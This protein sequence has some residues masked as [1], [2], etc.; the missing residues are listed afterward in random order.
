M[1][2]ILSLSLV[3]SA[4]AA[5]AAAG[6]AALDACVPADTRPPPG[7][8]TLTV[9]PSPAVV[10]GV[11]TADG[12]AIAFDRVLVALGSAGLGDSCAIYGEANYDRVLDVT[13]KS[14]QKL[15]IL[16]GIGQCDVDFRMEAPSVDALLG[17]GV[18]Q[19]DKDTL[20]TPGGDH[21]V[22]IGG[23]SADIAISASRAGVT[24]RFHMSFRV[25][26]RYRDCSL[27][28]DSGLAVDLQSN[29]TLT[30]DIRIEAESMLRDD[31]D[32][33]SALRFDPFANADKNGDGVVTL[34]ELRAIP[35]ETVRDGGAFEAGTYEVTEGGTVQRGPPIV[36]ATFGD[37]VY[38]VLVP[39]LTR[40]RDTGSCTPTL[41]HQ[42]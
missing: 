41:R 31:V 13:S 23:I 30:Y 10:H 35:I 29:V 40:Y 24:K 15:G 6:V 32:A 7:T 22:P 18:S 17:D 28:P 5:L 20:R 11:V 37:Y 25:P 33:S 8:L 38:E 3:A 21:Y 12:W 42:D 27:A 14:D 26:I 36:I 39:T 16:Y 2:R 1:R 19:A 9:S 34:D 4:L